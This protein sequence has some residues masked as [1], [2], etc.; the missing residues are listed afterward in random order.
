MSII[1]T[2]EADIDFDEVRIYDV[3]NELRGVSDIVDIAGIKYSFI[4][5]FSNRS[6]T[7]RFVLSSN[8]TEIDISRTF[9]FIDNNVLGSFS[10]PIV[11]TPVTLSDESSVINEISLYPNPFLDEITINFS[12]QNGSESKIEVFNVI[13]K[14][15]LSQTTKTQQKFVINTAKLASGM[16]VVR[17]TTD[18]GR[19]ISKKIIKR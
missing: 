8:S 6:E 18:D 3:N 14:L 10:D 4:T 5:A 16:Y 17:I 19:I 11:L 9:N 13:G 12:S 2:V 1:A 15:L 7:L